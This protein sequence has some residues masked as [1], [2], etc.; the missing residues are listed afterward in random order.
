MH[1]IQTGVRSFGRSYLFIFV[2]GP[3]E[4]MQ[5]SIFPVHA[6]S[7]PAHCLFLA[8]VD[9]YIHRAIYDCYRIVDLCKPEDAYCFAYIPT[10]LYVYVYTYFVYPPEVLWKRK[11]SMAHWIHNRMHFICSG[12]TWTTKKVHNTLGLLKCIEM[13]NRLNWNHIYMYEFCNC[14][15]WNDWLGTGDQAHFTIHNSHERIR[16]IERE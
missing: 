5:W 9:G 13:A 4:Q 10:I 11:V 2:R 15:R 8:L 1:C 3:S 12:E 14:R 6:H 7:S 16:W